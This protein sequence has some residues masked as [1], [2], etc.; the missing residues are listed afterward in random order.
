[1]QFLG[2]FFFVDRLWN[3]IAVMLKCAFSARP[4]DFNSFGRCLTMAV[5]R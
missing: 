1:M 3:P 4:G 2:L 5:C